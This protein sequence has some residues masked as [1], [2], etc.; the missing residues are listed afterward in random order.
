MVKG[1]TGCLKKRS[2]EYV[3]IVVLVTHKICRPGNS[4]NCVR[5][6]HLR[7]WCGGIQLGNYVSFACLH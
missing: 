3:N 4:K 7:L 1:K 2:N 5:L 6:A